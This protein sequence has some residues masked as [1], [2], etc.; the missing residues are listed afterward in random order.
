[1]KYPRIAHAPSSSKTDPDDLFTDLD[2]FNREWFVTEKVDG[3]QL[4]AQFIDR[5]PDVRNRNTDILHGGSDRQF[6]PFPAWFNAR[7][8]AIW[9][10]LGSDRILFGEWMFHV[11][12]VVYTKLPD[13]FVAFDLYDKAR[14]SFIPFEDAMAVAAG[15]GLFHVPI[16]GKAV[17]RDQKHLLSFISTSKFGTEEMEGLV[18]HS[19]DGDDRVKF[20]TGRFKNSIDSSS[21][22]WRWESERKKNALSTSTATG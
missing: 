2:I 13:W 14:E 1:M 22:H 7:Y 4:S 16:L 8:G 18:L 21:R 3:S 15:A 17:I 12:T 5:A 9:K 19:A 6:H 11:H 10:L 20:V